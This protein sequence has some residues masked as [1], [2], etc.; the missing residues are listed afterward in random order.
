MK[1]LDA[2]QR[3]LSFGD[4]PPLSLPMRFFLSAPLFAALDDDSAAVCYWVEQA[5]ER[6]GTGMVYF[7]P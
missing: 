4:N 6:R 1:P 3:A 7:Q 5:L 2:P